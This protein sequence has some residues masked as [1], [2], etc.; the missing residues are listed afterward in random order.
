MI[1][2]E[3]IFLLLL[4]LALSSFFSRVGHGWEWCLCM[5]MVQDSPAVANR[6][7]A[8][9]HTFLS[10]YIFIFTN[11]FVLAKNSTY[12]LSHPYNAW[13]FNGF[14]F[15][16]NWQTFE[17]K[18][19]KE[20]RARS[21]VKAFTHSFQIYLKTILNVHSIILI[22]LLSANG[23]LFCA[24]RPQIEKQKSPSTHKSQMPNKFALACWKSPV[25]HSAIFFCLHLLF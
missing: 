20:K 16:Y 10:C 25:F 15:A 12:S 22:I 5:C 7:C 13:A 19:E 14:M 4:H 17:K 3:F 9:S 1:S 6:F 18:K 24:R 11:Y 2:T 23:F 8:Q 21:F